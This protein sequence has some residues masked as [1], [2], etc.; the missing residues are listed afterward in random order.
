[1]STEL[2]SFLN[3]LRKS[4]SLAS[5]VSRGC[6]HSLACGPLPASKLS[7]VGGVFLT[8]HHFDTESSSASA[9]AFKDPSDYL[10]FPK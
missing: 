4:I 3:D 8:L 5:S 1:M 2:R 6:L 7:V 10:G 9:S